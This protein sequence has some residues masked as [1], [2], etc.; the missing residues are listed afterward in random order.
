MLKLFKRMKYAILS[1]TLK[2]DIKKEY[3]IKTSVKIQEYDVE[4]KDGAVTTV[5]K[6]ELIA[7]KKDC[8]I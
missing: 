3:G 8:K 2:R 7:D 1:K 4:S 6:V 5:I